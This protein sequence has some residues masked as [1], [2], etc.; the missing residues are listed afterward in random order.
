MLTRRAA[1]KGGISAILAARLMG[2]SALASVDPNSHPNRIFHASHYGPFEAIVKDG[3]FV[4]VQP[5]Y[6][7]DARPTEMLMYGM[8]DRTYDK[9]RIL[10]PMVRKS[11]LE[12]WDKEDRKVELRGKEPYVRV[13]WDTALR[14]TAK[15]IIDTI[16]KHGNEGLFSS[17][18]GGWSHAGIFKP[19][20]LQG[21]F[22]NLIGGC[23]NTVGD[24]SGGAS[25]ISLPYVIGDMEVYSSQTAWQQIRDNTEVFVFVGCDPVKNNRIDYAVGDHQMQ[26]HWEE[27]RDAGVK[28]IS[29]NPQRTGS[30]AVLGS[31]WIKIVPNTDTALFLAMSHEVIKAGKI[32]KDFLARYTVGADKVIDNILGKDGTEPKTPEWAAKYT[33]IPAEKIVELAHLLAGKRTEIA[34][35]WSLQR[36]QHGE[37]THW[38]IINFAA[39]TGKI[40]LPGQGVGF[41]WHYGNGG[42]PQSGKSGPAGMSQGRN[43]VKAI[44]PASR[45][46]E[47]LLN[48]GKEFTRNGKAYKYPA[49]KLL[50]NA[51][52][53][54]MSHQQNL[55]ELIGALKVLDHVIVQ[56][57]WWAACTRWADIVLPSTCTVERD[58]ISVGGSYSNN[59]IYAMK[60]VID[61]VGESLD[62]F[63]I[64]RRLSALMGVE[65]QFTE[66]LTPMDFIK[67]G[68]DKSS[69]KDVMPFE[70]FWKKGYVKLETP[71]E[72]NKWVRHGDFR[73][74]PEKNH[75]HTASGK[76]E[77]F[78][79]GIA[80]QKLED[81]PGMPV[82]FEPAEYLGNAKEGQVHVVS[83]HPWFRIH[84]QMANSERLR[85]L[86]YVQGREPVRINSEDA[87][88]RGIADG[89]LVELSNERGAIVAGAVV[90]DDIMPG[91]VSIYEG[92]W[93]NPDSKG[94]CNNGLVNFITSS[95]RSS[96]LSQATT[97]NT[98]VASLKKCEDPEGPST[99][100]EPPKVLEGV[101][102]ASVEEEVIGVDR[103]SA[104]LEKMQAGMTPGEQI[105]YQRCTV[106][107]GPRDPAAYTKLQWQGVTKT[108]FERAGLESKE[109][110][111]VLEFLMKNA[112][113]AN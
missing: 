66:N 50:Y 6:E 65:I 59:V 35:A 10:Y 20:V 95:R 63:E 84:S 14:L 18:Y 80:K 113:D 107:H 112:A 88:K 38:A 92:A 36:A 54:F 103:L 42:M 73:A 19:N 45:I 110:E 101:K 39:L 1:I 79:E 102:F 57:A 69:G 23:T 77:M 32:D 24:Y 15:A 74:D 104:I 93:P 25:Q 30:D 5:M 29:I 105:F 89:D 31:E 43:L 83:P 41:S 60:K 85:E 111:L 2:G 108:M 94:R 96:A 81:C 27:I 16:D 100:Y 64:F 49:P 52:N 12:N 46:S 22:F 76:I 68:Y 97:A 21:R 61:P 40:G 98:C 87:K 71:A 58:D 33:G 26:A 11:Y 13:D 8:V 55:N 72:A 53:N 86:Y 70:E 28:F 90:S 9:T 7:L 37:M 48:P 67:N 4:G 78:C 34:G 51:G 75:L 17:S 3:K 56:D 109:R 106:C 99:A 44:C 91:V 82:F 62:D 47:M